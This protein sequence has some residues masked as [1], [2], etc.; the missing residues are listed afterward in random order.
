MLMRAY[1]VFWRQ[2][3]LS[4]LLVLFADAEVPVFQDFYTVSSEIFA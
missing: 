1:P 3:H 4:R 2:D